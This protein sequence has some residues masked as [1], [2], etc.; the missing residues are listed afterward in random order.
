MFLEVKLVLKYGPE[1]KRVREERGLVVQK[2]N[3][4]KRVQK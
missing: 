1:I 3:E 4:G 2:K